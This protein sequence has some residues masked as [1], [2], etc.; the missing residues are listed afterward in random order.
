M[1]IEKRTE[2]Q[3]T[4]GEISQVREISPSE[5]LNQVNFLIETTFADEGRQLTSGEAEGLN[6]IYDL[7]GSL[8][9][10]ETKSSLNPSF[11]DRDNRTYKLDLLT[12]EVATYKRTICFL[13][14]NEKSLLYG[15]IS[16][17][18]EIVAKSELYKY[19]YPDQKLVKEIDYQNQ[20]RLWAIK[21][22]LVKKL[23]DRLGECI[24]PITGGGYMWSTEDS[25]KS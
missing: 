14:K 3:V 16:N 24:Y 23:G 25:K 12:G 19:V 6:K 18:N 17:P 15:L 13:S 1:T 9:G 21:R 2:T 7:I 8:L 5:L 4:L 10:K 11:L 22:R 20:D